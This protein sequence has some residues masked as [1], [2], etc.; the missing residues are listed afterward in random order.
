MQASGLRI[1]FFMHDLSG[2]GVER[3]RLR[4]LPALA[5][6]GHLV[7]LIVQT[8]SGALLDVVPEA[9]TLVEL[10]TT[11]TSR[12]ILVLAQ[13]LRTHRQDMLVSSLDHNNIAAI[14]ARWLA[15]VPTGLVIC[16]HNALGAERVLGWRYR[17]VPA[18]YWLLAGGADAIVAV[19]AGVADDLARTAGIARDRITIIFNPVDGNDIPERAGAPLP[20]PWLVP[21]GIPVFVYAG[22]LVAQKDPALLLRALR[23]RL[24]RA[25]ARLLVL[26]EGEMQPVLRRQA[27][28]LDIAHAVEFCGFVADPLPWIARAAAFVLTSRY[29][30]F[31]N[32]IVE[33][34]ACGTPVIAADCP[35]G[36]A[37]I[38]AGGAFGR[39]VP[40]GDETGF[41]AA[42]GEDLRAA[43]PA[44]LLRERAAVFS[45]AACVRGHE[46][47]FERIGKARRRTAFGLSF[48]RMDAAS[49]AAHI[50][51]IAPDELR[52]VATPNLDHIQLL[53]RPEFAAACAS[54]AFAC[55]DGFPVALYAWL[56]GAGPARRLTGCD[57]F[58]EFAKQA[59]AVRQPVMVVVESMATGVVLLRWAERQGLAGL[60][61][62]EVAATDL[63]T[64]APA[65]VR[66]VAAAQQFQPHVLVITLGAPVSEEFIG[67]YRAMMPPCWVL[68]VGQGVRVELGIVLR[69]PVM[70]RRC[71]LEWAWRMC[72]E[73]RRLG[74]RYLR[75]ALWFPCAV[76][77]DLGRRVA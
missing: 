35:H 23:L 15:R 57:I 6:R 75:A 58:H 11:R 73:P 25:P 10:G 54:A 3:M 68:C 12:S 53:R 65:Q 32:V 67:C 16:Q 70:L 76:V 13:W 66:L 40:V 1:A 22:R 38:L 4:L 29:E 62:V 34:L 19:S 48:C 50:V 42:M 49:L 72:Q 39:L 8:A 36:P 51:S 55:A 2:G 44:G 77:R 7:T 56:R 69:A 74:G 45:V 21:G 33:A 30:R 18:L 63:A 9:V 31:G 17:V 41:A 5:A 60:W 46:A 37:E 59:I 61:R 28:E 52:L 71:G 14:M 26:G 27:A 24:L 43:F 47:L 20:H 64:D